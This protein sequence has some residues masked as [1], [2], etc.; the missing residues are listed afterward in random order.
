MNQIEQVGLVI[1]IILVLAFYLRLI[2]LQY[3]KARRINSKAQQAKKGKK[4]E[5]KPPQIP[6]FF[7]VRVTSWPWVIAACALLIAGAV[8]SAIPNVTTPFWWLPVD[9]GIIILWLFLK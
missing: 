9:G 8:M 1:T 4:N 5:N 3:G 6:F 2:I 7:G